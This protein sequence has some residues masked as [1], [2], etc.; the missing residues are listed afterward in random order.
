MGKKLLKNGHHFVICMDH[1]VRD[2]PSSEAKVTHISF[3]GVFPGSVTNHIH[4][5]SI[6]K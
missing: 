1:P 2:S 6:E 4:V 5:L 3:L